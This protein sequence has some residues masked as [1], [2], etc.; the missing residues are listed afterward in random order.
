MSHGLL[1]RSPDHV[2]SFVTGMAMNPEVFK[3]FREN[4]LDYYEHMRREDVYGVYAVL[5]PQAARNPEF[6][7]K[8][9]LPM[10]TLR[11]VREDDDGVVISRHED[12]RHRRGVR[13]RDLDRQPAAARAE[14]ARRVDHLRD[15]GQR[16]GA[17]AL[18]AQA[19]RAP[20]ADRIRQPA[21]LALRRDRLDGDVRQRQGA[22]GAR[23]R[24][25]GRDPGARDLHQDPGPLLRQPPVERALPRQ[26]A[27]ASSGWRARSRTPP[28]RTR[29]RRC[30]RC[31]GASPR[32]RRRSAA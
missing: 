28:A 6:Y 2:S 15:P 26:D 25:Q 31:S 16:D 23:V 17:D 11:V 5:P 19:L 10:P 9:N 32:S 27:A 20:R 4:L 8:Q 14:P 1:G 29:C 24:A 22:V 7:V 21:H 12:A 30:A 3:G 18:V 13:Q